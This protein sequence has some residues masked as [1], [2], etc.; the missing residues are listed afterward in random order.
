AIEYS[1]SVRVAT[2]QSEIHEYHFRGM[3]VGSKALGEH[4]R[5][6]VGCCKQLPA[7]GLAADEG[8]RPTALDCPLVGKPCGIGRKR[9][10]HRTR[11]YFLLTD[12]VARR[13]EPVAPWGGPLGG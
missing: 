5:P 7:R 8:V 10:S 13:A 9:L 3:P 4:C 1:R 11:A 2:C 6:W 12:D